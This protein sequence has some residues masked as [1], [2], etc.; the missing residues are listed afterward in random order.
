MI[1]VIIEVEDG[2]VKY[3]DTFPGG[4]KIFFA[5]FLQKTFI[6]KNVIYTLQALLGDGVVVGSFSHLP[7]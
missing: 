1:L 2:F 3:R 7:I 4:P 5:D 6:A